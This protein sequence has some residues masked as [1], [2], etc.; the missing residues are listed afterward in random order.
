MTEID[1]IVE[2]LVLELRRGTL[3][4][5]VLSQL[6]GPRYGYALVQRLSELGMPIDAGTL[7]PLLRRLEAQGL[8]ASSWE[9]ADAR[10]RRYYQLSDLGGQVLERLLTQWREMARGV[11]QLTQNG[12]GEG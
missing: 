1:T 12:G 10:P 9:L 7:Y 2:G 6:R 11:E 8:L 4:M 3:V 5:S